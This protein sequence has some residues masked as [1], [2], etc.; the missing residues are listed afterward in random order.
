M[1]K[2][3][4]IFDN[5]QENGGKIIARAGYFTSIK[6]AQ[7]YADNNGCH[8]GYLTPGEYTKETIREQKS[9]AKAQKEIIATRTPKNPKNA[10]TAKKKTESQ[11]NLL[12]KTKPATSE[13]KSK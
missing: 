2:I 5:K 11:G 9:A 8:V 1:K 3:Y 10:P 13:P 4:V 6:K 7:W 12:P